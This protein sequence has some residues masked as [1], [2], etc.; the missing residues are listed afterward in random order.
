MRG[1]SLRVEAGESV[2]IVGESGSGKTLT[3][4]SV[5]GMLPRTARVT[6]G[7]VAFK[8]ADVTELDERR[9]RYIRGRQIGTILQDPL[10]CLN[11]THTVGNQ[12]AEPLRQ[13]LGMGRAE[14]R[15]RVVEL[16][17]D[18]RIPDPER[19]ARA[20]PHEMSG[21]MKQ[22][23]GSAIA[24]SC[25]PELIIADEPTTALDVTIQG[26]YLELLRRLQ[27]ETGCALILVTHDLS[28]VSATCDRVLVMYAGRIVE[29]GPTATVLSEPRHPYTAGLLRS[30]PRLDGPPVPRLPSIPGQPPEPSVEIPGCSFAPRCPMRIPACEER[31]PPLL[32]FGPDH[33]SACIRAEEVT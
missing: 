30:L 21:G 15:R 1:V 27:R 7:E 18:V 20:Y 3:C 9:I 14:R 6:A 24:L 22:R 33:H 25:E 16:L 19:R 29:E 2:G 26:Q 8:G 10:S 23:V 4:M 32:S 13:H 5:V 11:P 17:R 31:L 28:V 12:I